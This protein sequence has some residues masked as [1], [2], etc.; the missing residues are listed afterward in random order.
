[1]SI[2]RQC[3]HA[4]IVIGNGNSYAILSLH[5]KINGIWT[6]QLS[7]EARIGKN[8]ITSN[9]QEGDGKTSSGIYSFGQA[10]GITQNP[11][12]R[13]NWLQVNNNH[14]WVDDINSP[15]YNQLVDASQTGIQWNSA[16]RLISYTTAYN[17]AIA[18]NYNTAC[19]PGA[20]SAIF[21]HCSTGGPTAGCISV[22]QT[23]LIKILQSLQDDTLIGIYS[24][25]NSLY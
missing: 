7:C 12:T 14:Y 3:N 2:S 22:N 18:L 10:F 1:M 11:G 24:D 9:K 5:T 13:R 21:L 16:E 17:Y 23:N 4:I 8:G 6:E 25:S 19:I 20:G 15:Y